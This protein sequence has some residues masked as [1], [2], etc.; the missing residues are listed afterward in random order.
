MLLMRRNWAR[1]AVAKHSQPI[2]SSQSFSLHLVALEVPGGTAEP[3][4]KTKAMIRIIIIG[5]SV[6]A[7]KRFLLLTVSF[8]SYG[9]LSKLGESWTRRNHQNIRDI[10]IL[11]MEGPVVWRMIAQ[12][13]G[14]NTH[15]DEND[16]VQ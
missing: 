7:K 3:G 16:P 11:E 12:E 2:C 13:N 10:G 15:Y 9:K 1:I 8:L 6:L 14:N 4:T 5:P